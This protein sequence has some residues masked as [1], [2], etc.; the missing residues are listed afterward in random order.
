MG[1]TKN[2][3]QV[4]VLINFYCIFNYFF[5]NSGKS[6][7]RELKMESVN[8]FRIKIIEFLLKESPEEKQGIK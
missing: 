3:V 6:K 4:R 2:R 1:K 7:E 5:Y 8:G